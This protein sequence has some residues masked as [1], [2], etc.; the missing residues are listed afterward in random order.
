MIGRYGPPVF[1]ILRGKTGTY[2]VALMKA[3]PIAGA[4]IND[5]LFY[6]LSEPRIQSLVI[7]ESERTA[8]QSGV[9]KELIYQF[10]IALPPVEEQARIVS[11]VDELMALCDQLKAHLNKTQTTQLHLADALAEQAVG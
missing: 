2:N 11:K 3:E 4:L 9:R 6:L 10:P 5:Y 8:G 1:Q 7:S